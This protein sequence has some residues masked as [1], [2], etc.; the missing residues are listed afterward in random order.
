MSTEWGSDWTLGRRVWIERSDHTILGPGRLELL[1]AIDRWRSISAAARQMGMSYRRAWLLVQAVN[2]AAG[3]PLVEAAVGGSHGGGAQLT[4]QGRAAVRVFRNLE[5]Q[6]VQTAASLLPQL[7]ETPVA[8]S[9][10]V[11]AAASLEE[12]S[13]R[14]LAEYSL[15]R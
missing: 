11:A 12:V 8:Q 2:E 7:I 10:H 9:V 6:I 3:E 15:Q 5:R 13:G 1:R 4:P 14:L